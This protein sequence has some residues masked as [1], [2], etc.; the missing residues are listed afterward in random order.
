MGTPYPSDRRERPTGER[1]RGGPHQS[2]EERGRVFLPRGEVRTR[3]GFQDYGGVSTTALSPPYRTQTPVHPT[4][5]YV[6][7]PDPSRTPVH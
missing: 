3:Q 4:P 5:T 1:E 2:N 6:H 7:P